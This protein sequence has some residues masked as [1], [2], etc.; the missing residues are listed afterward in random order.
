MSNSDDVLWGIHAG[1]TGDADSLFLQ[2]NRI[3]LGWHEVGDLAGIQSDRESFKNRVASVYPDLTPG[4]KINCS[5]QLFRFVHEMK[6]GDLVCYPSKADRQIHIGK[7]V[8]PYQYDPTLVPGY[9]QQ[10]P[11]QWL[12]SVPRTT[13]SQGALYEIGSALSL[14]QLKN[15]A[16]EFRQAAEGKP[17]QTATVANDVTVALVTEEVEETTKDFVLKKLARDL[18]GHA[19]ADFIAH[20]LGTM[21][22]RTRVSPEGADG[23]IDIIAHRDELGFEPPIIKVQVKSTEGSVGDPIVSQLYG[24]L[25]GNEYGLL[26]TLG[27]FTVQAKTFARN[28]HNLRLIDGDELVDLIF[29]HYEEFDSR[30]KGALPLKRIYV[31]EAVEESE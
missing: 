29:Q 22:Y 5:S 18:K 6:A 11:V 30:Y 15:Y 23:G 12:N 2:K 27:A 9:P 25:T 17:I 16:D 24:K 10:R 1:K 14:F 4:A 13:F 31:A 28:R 21:G 20:L 8:G 19:F 3:A 26:V 7:V